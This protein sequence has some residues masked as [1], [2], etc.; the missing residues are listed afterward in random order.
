MHELRVLARSGPITLWT[1]PT[2]D[3]LHLAIGP[4]TVRLSREVLDHLASVLRDGSAPPAP[5]LAVLSATPADA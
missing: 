2:G 1:C 4:V 5:D 3:C